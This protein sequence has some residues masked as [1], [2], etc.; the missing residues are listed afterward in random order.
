MQ[1]DYAEYI[2]Q[3]QSVLDEL[4]AID[5]ACA[6]NDANGERSNR[7]DDGLFEGSQRAAVTFSGDLGRSSHPFLC[8]PAP[9]ADAHT[10]AIEST[11]G[12]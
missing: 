11:Y 3:S 10:I 9:P 2:I 6:G 5:K 1:G 4:E 8:P 7:V 12:D